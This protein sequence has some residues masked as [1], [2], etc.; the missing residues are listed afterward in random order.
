MMHELYAC[1]LFV[2]ELNDRDRKFPGRP[3][4]AVTS[5]FQSPLHSNHCYGGRCIILTDLFLCISMPTYART[6][7]M[8]VLKNIQGSTQHAFL[9]I[10]LFSPRLTSQ[11]SFCVGP[12]RAPSFLMRPCVMFRGTDATSFFKTIFLLIDI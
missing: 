9:C 5:T 2:R 7:A 10:W 3:C 12:Y 4:S 11:T 6:F 8:G 1:I